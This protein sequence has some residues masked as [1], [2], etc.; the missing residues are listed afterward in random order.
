MRLGGSEHLAVPSGQYYP[1]VTSCYLLKKDG[2]WW[3]MGNRM[4][5]GRR[6][7]LIMIRDMIR[8]GANILDIA[9]EHFGSFVRYHRGIMLYQDLL[10]R[11]EQRAAQMVKP[12][13]V[14]Y[15][16]KSF[17]KAF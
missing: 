6:N 3:E 9:D 5:Q 7:D 15:I 4:Q 1:L 16:I 13:V 11:R 14:V 12:E 8:N 17:K 10:N 2:N